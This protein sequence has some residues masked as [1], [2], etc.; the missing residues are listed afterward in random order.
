MDLWVQEHP[1][2]DQIF[3]NSFAQLSILYP[4]YILFS[5]GLQLLDKFENQHIRLNLFQISCAEIGEKIDTYF[6]YL[7]IV[8]RELTLYILLIIHIFPVVILSI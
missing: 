8:S 5:T 3:S 4:R 2:E 1:P 7:E 6:F